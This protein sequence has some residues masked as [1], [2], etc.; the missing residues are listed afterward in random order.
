M[1]DRW[2]RVGDRKENGHKKSLDDSLNQHCPIQLPTD[3]GSRNNNWVQNDRIPH[4]R[5][6][7]FTDAS[8]RGND[9]GYAFLAS[10][11]DVVIGEGGGALG[12]VSVF[13]TEVV[14]IQA[15]LL[16][17]ISNPHKLKGTKV[18]L[19]TDSQ[20]A[21]QSVFSLKPTSS[22]VEGTIK[23]LM[24]TKL[25]CQIE[26]AWVRGH[27]G[28]TGNKV[29]D[30]MAKENT[31]AVHLSSPA[32]ER[33]GREIKK[34][35]KGIAERQWQQWWRTIPHCG[36]AKSFFAVPT[37]QHRNCI[38]WMSTKELTTLIQAATGHG[39]FASHLSKWRESLSST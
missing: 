2:D 26:L 34:E 9:T 35:I 39:L 4:P 36:I 1:W 7:F 28:V 8:K 14:A 12:D 32:L 24:S 37:T 6:Q 11:G 27:S 3:V 38:K 16:W 17:L 10:R 22:L 13:Q 5:V 31:V 15:T 19:W 30:G 29:A 23:L 25:I 21:L 33:T 20:S 18:K